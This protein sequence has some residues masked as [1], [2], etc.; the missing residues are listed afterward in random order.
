MSEGFSI[1]PAP[2]VSLSD[3]VGKFLNSVRGDS[4]VEALYRYASEKQ[5]QLD[6]FLEP[7]KSPAS[8]HPILVILRR[9]NSYTPLLPPS[10]G[11]CLSK[12]GGYFVRVGET[13]V[14]IDPGYNFI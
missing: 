9:F 11:E 10:R 8:P 2:R 13:G 12:G 5:L 4:T 14:V 1:P 3:L 7:G 6:R